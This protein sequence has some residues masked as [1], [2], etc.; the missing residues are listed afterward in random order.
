[1]DRLRTGTPRDL[2]AHAPLV[3][4]RAVVARLVRLATRRDLQ[5]RHGRPGAD[6]GRRRDDLIGRERSDERA[7]DDHLDHQGGHSVAVVA[8][9]DRTLLDG[10]DAEVHLVDVLLELVLG[11]RLSAAPAGAP[12]R[13]VRILPRASDHVPGSVCHARI[14]L[15]VIGGPFPREWSRVNLFYPT[16]P[17]PTMLMSSAMPLHFFAGQERKISRAGLYAVL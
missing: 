12:H 11:H 15:D 9:S 6:D 4:G 14:L 16:P 7:V 5:R 10:L 13:L 8:V 3:R 1:M 17:Y 2:A